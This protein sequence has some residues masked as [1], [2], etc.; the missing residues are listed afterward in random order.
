MDHNVTY[1]H[2]KGKIVVTCS[3]GATLG[4]HANH[5]AVYEIGKAHI[6]AEAAK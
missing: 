5:P 6:R 4:R 2:T 1:V 3:C